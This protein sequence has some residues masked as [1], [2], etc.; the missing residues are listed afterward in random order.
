MEGDLNSISVLAL[1]VSVLALA[2]AVLFQAW[3]D[4]RRD[5][6]DD[7]GGEGGTPA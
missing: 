2:G 4:R 3:V 6:G 1:N 5:G 7:S